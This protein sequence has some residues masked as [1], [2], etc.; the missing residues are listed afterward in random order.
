MAV[1]SHTSR[2]GCFR[3]IVPDDCFTRDS[4]RK[5]PGALRVV[6]GDV[7]SNWTFISKVLSLKSAIVYSS[8]ATITTVRSTML[9]GGG[10]RFLSSTVAVEAFVL[11]SV[12][13]GIASIDAANP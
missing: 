13:V 2:N 3:V 1:S 6:C 12:A 8:S 7:V 5:G 9:P 4:R 10:V 11:G